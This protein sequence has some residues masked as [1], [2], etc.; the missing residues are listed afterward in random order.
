MV[1]HGCAFALGELPSCQVCPKNASWEPC[2]TLAVAFVTTAVLHQLW[3]LDK[4]TDSL[5]LLAS[6]CNCS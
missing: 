1:G 4:G 5:S 3:L 6:S 2:L